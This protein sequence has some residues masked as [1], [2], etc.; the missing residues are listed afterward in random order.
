MGNA[1]R[2]RRTPAG[3]GPESWFRRG[4]KS[5]GVHHPRLMAL[6]HELGASGRDDVVDQLSG[7]HLLARKLSLPNS[8]LS[9]QSSMSLSSSLS[10]SLTKSKSV[11]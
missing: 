4:R 1:E 5:K 9:A 2:G 7:P 8:P 6:L 11:G 10:P 3:E